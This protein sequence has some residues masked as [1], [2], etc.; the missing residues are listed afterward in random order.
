[1]TRAPRSFLV[2]VY[3]PPAAVLEDLATGRHEHVADVADLGEHVARAL[4]AG[5]RSDERAGEDSL[6]QLRGRGGRLDADDRPPA[7][8]DLP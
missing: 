6:L 2:T 8:D 7:R 3:E 5:P 4:A 1:M